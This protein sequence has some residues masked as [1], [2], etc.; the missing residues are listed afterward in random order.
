MN[1]IEAIKII[2]IEID[3]NA[4]ILSSLPLRAQERSSLQDK[5]KALEMA[6]TVLKKQ[7]PM[8]PKI[9]HFKPY[10]DYND[11]W[12][13]CC[14]AY[15]QELEYDTHFCQACGQTLAWSDNNDY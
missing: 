2:K 14:D 15:V 6:I 10:D 4:D 8:K 12:C 7:I 13:P 3:N 5:I 9:R 11:G 1:E